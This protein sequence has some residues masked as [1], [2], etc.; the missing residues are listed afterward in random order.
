MSALILMAFCLGNILG[1]LTFR[2]KDAPRYVPAKIAIVATLAVS[3]VATALLYPYY[4]WEN[5]RRDKR[6]DQGEVQEAE[7]WSDMTDRQN[8]SFRYCL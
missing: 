5:A 1:P 2:E 3:L 6:R 7:A 8:K 4:K